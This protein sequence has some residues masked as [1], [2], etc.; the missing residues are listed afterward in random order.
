MAKKT[1]TESILREKPGKAPKIKVSTDERFK[2]LKSISIISVVLVIAICIV[3]NMI[4]DITLD[5]KLTFD[6]SSVKQYSVSSITEEYLDSLEKKVE[7]IGL[8]DKNDTSLEWRDYFVPLLDDY[9]SKANGMIELKYVDPS[10]DPFIIEQLDPNRIYGLQQ[11]TYV[12][13][14]GDVLTS[15]YPYRCF[16]YDTDMQ[17]YYGINMPVTNRVEEIFTVNI[18]YVTSGRPLHAYYVTGHNLP[19]HNRLDDMLKTLGFVTSELDLKSTGSTI[20]NDCELLILLEPKTDLTL[21]EKEIMK[22]YLDNSGKMLLV[23]DFSDNKTT[24]FTNLNEVA[25]R[26]GVT[27]EQGVIHEN[28]GDYLMDVSD[29]Y[30]SIGVVTSEYEQ[31]LGVPSTYSVENCR[32]IKVDRDKAETIYVSALVTTSSS[33]SVDF[34]NEQIDSDVSA[35]IYPVILQ[36][37]DTE[38]KDR[39]CLIVIGTKAFTSDEYYTEKTMEDNNAVLMKSMIHDVCPVQYNLIIP[40]RQVPSYMLTKPL[41]SSQATM[42]SVVVMTVI[43]LGCLVCG[44]YVYYRR[45]HL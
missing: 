31:Y 14:C 41:S 34:Q 22:T 9:E 7:I 23:S 30:R 18:L 44:I 20:P 10:V 28:D 39:A 17:N 29:P 11:Y 6:T 15:I 27:L 8:F 45:R 21:S 36:C 12:V 24:A 35:G 3:F 26:M 32:Y 19:T 38:P 2:S 13:K 5:D 33:A 43:P 25:R 4:I 16:E 42:W 1:A 37:V 40:N